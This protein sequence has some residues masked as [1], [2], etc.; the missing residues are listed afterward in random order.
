MET[1]SGSICLPRPFPTHQLTNSLTHRI[2]PLT[3]SPGR[4]YSARGSRVP[5]F[6]SRCITHVVR[7]RRPTLTRAGRQAII[8]D[9]ICVFRVHD[10]PRTRGA[11]FFEPKGPDVHMMQ[12]T[13]TRISSPR[14]TGTYRFAASWCAPVGANG[15]GAHAV[16][17]GLDRS[18][19]HTSGLWSMQQVGQ[20]GIEGR[21]NG[22]SM[23]GNR[24]LDRDRSGA[25]S[26]WSAG[27]P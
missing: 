9:A 2:P 18:K 4:R 6:T 13:L 12:R 14:F 20:M 24:P 8:G 5:M 25:G 15:A 11:T 27:A 1:A 16:V 21:S 7:A 19:R 22:T 23:S 17:F 3:H 26:R 10:F